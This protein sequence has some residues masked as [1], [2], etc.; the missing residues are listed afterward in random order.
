MSNSHSIAEEGLLD[1]NVLFFFQLYYVNCSYI[2]AIDN[3][4]D[5]SRHVICL[6]FPLTSYDNKKLR[7]RILYRFREALLEISISEV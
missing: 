7:S 4:I 3:Y 5:I 1:L 6:L 2:F